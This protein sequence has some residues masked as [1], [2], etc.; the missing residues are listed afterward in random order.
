MYRAL[1]EINS[2][3]SGGLDSK[4]GG[5]RLQGWVQPKQERENFE[6]KNRVE[7]GAHSWGGVEGKCL[8]ARVWSSLSMVGA[9]GGSNR[10]PGV[11]QRSWIRA[12]CPWSK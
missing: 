11:V 10:W 4:R 2:V 7:R 12:V 8:M 6:L 1:L 9:S 3:G 5:E